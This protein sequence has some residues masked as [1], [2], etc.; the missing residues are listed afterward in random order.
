M[1]AELD[2]NIQSGD[3]IEIISRTGREPLVR[4]K[5][6]ALCTMCAEEHYLR[7]KVCQKC[8]PSLDNELRG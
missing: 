1:L 8:K 2:N 6:G 5:K 7:G 3:R 4:A